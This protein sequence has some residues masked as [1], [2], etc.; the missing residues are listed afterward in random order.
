MK[1]TTTG[2]GT[3]MSASEANEW[4]KKS[5]EIEKLKEQLRDLGETP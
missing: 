3:G 1:D 2:A 4:L 5:S